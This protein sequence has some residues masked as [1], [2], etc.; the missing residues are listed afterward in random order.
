MNDITFSFVPTSQASAVSN[1][2]G[3]QS[4]SGGGRG[5]R[6]RLFPVSPLLGGNEPATGDIRWRA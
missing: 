5:G 4:G 6:G 3:L 1:Y 2:S